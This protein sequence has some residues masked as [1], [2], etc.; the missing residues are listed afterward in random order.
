MSYYVTEGIV[1]KSSDT[2]FFKDFDPVAQQDFEQKVKSIAVRVI[3]TDLNENTYSWK[4]YWNS[5]EDWQIYEEQKKS[6]ACYH[7]RQAYN[8]EHN[9]NVYETDTYITDELPDESD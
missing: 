2:V 5:L 4:V 3:T 9:I 1:E 6:W 8:I 7:E